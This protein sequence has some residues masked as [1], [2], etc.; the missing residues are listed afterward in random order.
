MVLPCVHL[1]YTSLKKYLYNFL[2]AYRT[3]QISSF[4]SIP[5]FTMKHD[6]YGSC[7][8]CNLLEASHKHALLLSTLVFWCGSRNVGREKLGR[9]LEA[10]SS[11]FLEAERALGGAVRGHIEPHPVSFYSKVYGDQR[12]VGWL[13]FQ[14]F[15]TNFCYTFLFAVWF[16]EMLVGT[17]EGSF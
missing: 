2:H 14:D 10:R 1:L 17:V 11:L 12:F 3:I 15:L 5:H 16:P 7:I 8:L 6:K 9:F 13:C 4:W